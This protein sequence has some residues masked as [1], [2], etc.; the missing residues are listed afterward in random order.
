MEIKDFDLKEYDMKE[1][2]TEVKPVVERCLL[3]E[4][5]ENAY[6]KIIEVDKQEFVVLVITKTCTLWRIEFVLE[7]PEKWESNPVQSSA[8]VHKCIELTELRRDFEELQ[9][10]SSEETNKAMLNF[11]MEAKSWRP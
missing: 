8:R 11:F 2:A 10:L 7:N 9:G 5:A 4:G 1:M 3:Q 6:F